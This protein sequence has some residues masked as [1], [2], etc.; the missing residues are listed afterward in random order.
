M[1]G[2]RGKVLEGT[3][4]QIAS[5]ILESKVREQSRKPDQLYEIIEN[6]YPKGRF[7]ELFGRLHNLR[8]GWVTIGNELSVPLIHQEHEVFKS[9]SGNVE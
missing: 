2:A 5:S 8:N 4:R 7:I 3:R 1:I 6:L 9:Q